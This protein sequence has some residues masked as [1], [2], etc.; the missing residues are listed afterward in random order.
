MN[1]YKDAH[2]VS[3]GQLDW[4]AVL[5][6]LVYRWGDQKFLQVGQGEVDAPLG[7]EEASRS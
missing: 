4:P 6:V 2:N 1:Q 3:T 5:G 7:G